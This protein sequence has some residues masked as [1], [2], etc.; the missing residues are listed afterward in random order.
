[1]VCNAETKIL[2]LI[3]PDQLNLTLFCSL[4]ILYSDHRKNN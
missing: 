4:L 1:M 2:I 3:Y